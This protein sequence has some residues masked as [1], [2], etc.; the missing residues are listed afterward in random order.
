[1]QPETKIG[2]Q[3]KKVEIKQMINKVKNN[4]FNI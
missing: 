1:M 2:Y 4:L 3:I